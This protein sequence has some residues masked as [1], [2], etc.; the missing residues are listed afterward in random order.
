[1]RFGGVA[2]EFAAGFR[3]WERR[4]KAAF[5]IAAALLAGIL[6]VG[7]RLP[8]TMQSSVVIAV[9]GLLVA[10]QAIFLYANRNMVTPFTK[11][12]RLILNGYHEAAVELLEATDAAPDARTLALLGG[13]YRMLGRLEESRKTLTKAL[14]I[15]P[16]HHFA[17]YSFGRTLLASGEY[18]DAVSVFRRAIEHG[19]PAFAQVD[20]AEAEYRAGHDVAPISLDW[21][22]PHVALMAR[23]ID[24]QARRGEPPPGTLVERGLP[25]WEATAQRF[26]HT[27]YGADLTRDIDVLVR[28]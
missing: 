28:L 19:A 14:Q 2:R 26:A 25:F 15:S 12:Q 8:A 20:L 23:F 6:F 10:M 3:G 1:M 18:A 4:S 17:L 13:A 9:V 21:A 27:R 5:A 16:D 11:A 22:E 7:S 24:W